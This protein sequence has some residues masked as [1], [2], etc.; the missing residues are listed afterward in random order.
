MEDTGRIRKGITPGARRIVFGETVELDTIELFHLTQVDKAH[1]LMLTERA[2]LPKELACA[3]LR[4]IDEL[5]D[6]DF[7]PLRGAHAARG[8]YLLYESYLIER[9]GMEVGGA[10]QTARSRNDLNA[11][12]LRLRLRAPYLS[13]LKEALRLQ[14]VLLRR[15][16]INSKL[17]MPAYTHYQA[18]LPVTYGHYLAGVAT[19]LARD[20][21]T[22]LS[23]SDEINL[24]P[25]GAG[26]VGGTTFPID[27]SRTASLLGFAEPS[28]NSVDAVASRDLVLRILSCAAI[29]GVMLSRLSADLLLWTTVEYG[30]ISLPDELVGSSSMMPQ[31]RNPFLIEQAQGRSSYALGA[32]VSAATAMHGTPFT[33]SVA[34]GTEATSNLL[35]ALQRLTEATT[36]L[37]LVVDGAKPNPERMLERATQGHTAATELANRLV[38]EGGRPFREAHRKVGELVTQAFERGVTLEEVAQDSSHEDLNVRLHGL[39][40]AAVAQAALFGGGPGAINECLERLQSSWARQMRTSRAIREAWKDAERRLEEE[41]EKLCSLSAVDSQD[42]LS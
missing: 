26:A 16:R 9:L 30:F 15:A 6:S 34:V 10:L 20:I 5:R 2:I 31:K 23:L 3:L 38:I 4:G 37:R 39:D 13:L 33:N 14:A 29:M 7:A 42:V 27:A 11:T 28:L 18:A 24:C 17:T 25:L 35:P 40:P 21:E 1:V 32:L 12:M 36:L 8:L 41:Q 19:A 22:L